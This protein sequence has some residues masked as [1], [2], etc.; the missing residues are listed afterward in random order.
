MPPVVIEPPVDPQIEKSAHS[1]TN[2]V[3]KTLLPQTNPLAFIAYDALRKLT[4][5]AAQD[6]NEVFI[7]DSEGKL[8]CS[9]NLIPYIDSLSQKVISGLLVSGSRYLIL[10]FTIPKTRQEVCKKKQLPARGR[11]GGM[12]GGAAPRGIAVSVYKTVQPPCN[13]VII[14]LE[15]VLA[16]NI[17]AINQGNLEGITSMTTNSPV[18]TLFPIDDKHVL[19]GK[20]DG[21][22][23]VINVEEG[24]LIKSYP[25]EIKSGVQCIAR[26]TTNTCI[27]AVA[28]MQGV[29]FVSISPLNQRVKPI[30]SVLKDTDVRSIEHIDNDIWFVATNSMDNKG[31]SIYKEDIDACRLV[32]ESNTHMPYLI[33]RL[34]ITQFIL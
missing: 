25:L 19:S 8:L 22:I 1:E 17:E 34:S 6:S 23:D 12:R 20:K 4:Y 11:R 18:W 10:G 9:L 28:T 3:Y 13:I 2:L 21:S 7:T 32:K 5:S 15:K 33:R 27:F 26:H 16:I 30:K 31:F 14:N 24:C 29:C